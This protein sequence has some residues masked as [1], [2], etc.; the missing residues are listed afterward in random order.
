MDIKR[1]ISKIEGDVVGL[2]GNFGNI[3]KR[4]RGRVYAAKAAILGGFQ[5]T[6]S[7]KSL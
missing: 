7:R 1:R 6:N 4:E 5:L 3:L 2:F